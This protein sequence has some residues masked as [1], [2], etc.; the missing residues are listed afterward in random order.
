MSGFVERSLVLSHF[1]RNF[2]QKLS[3]LLQQ[4]SLSV[5][6]LG[7]DRGIDV[8]ELK[9]EKLVMSQKRGICA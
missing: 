4:W 5:E 3:D 6:T 9:F 8:F 1:A 2:W 7:I